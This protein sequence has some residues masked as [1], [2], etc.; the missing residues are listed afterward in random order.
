VQFTYK[1]KIFTVDAVAQQNG[2]F[3]WRFDALLT[4]RT[5]SSD[6]PTREMAIEIGRK[7][8][9]AFIDTQVKG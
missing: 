7:E 6:L 5:G 1:T 2:A 8:A 4:T 3:R 9:Q